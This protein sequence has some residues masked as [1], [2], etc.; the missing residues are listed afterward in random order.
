MVILMLVRESKFK[1]F[2]ELDSSDLGVESNGKPIDE[3]ERRGQVITS[4][5]SNISSN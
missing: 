2:G 5:V 3:E 1:P 4:H